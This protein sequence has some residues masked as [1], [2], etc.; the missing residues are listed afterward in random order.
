MGDS[1]F[2]VFAVKLISKIVVFSLISV[3]KAQTKTFGVCFVRQLRLYGYPGSNLGKNS[4]I[5]GLDFHRHLVRKN[6]ETY[7]HFSLTIC[8]LS[9]IM[10]LVTTHLDN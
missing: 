9:A 2:D 5:C 4:L 10:Y 3:L 6:G 8:A 1:F 7:P